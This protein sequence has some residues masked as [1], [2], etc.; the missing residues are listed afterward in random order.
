MITIESQ[1]LI[2]SLKQDD[3]DAIKCFLRCICKND[4]CEHAWKYT[5]HVD[6]IQET[7]MQTVLSLTIELTPDNINLNDKYISYRDSGKTFVFQ[8]ASSYQTYYDMFKRL[9]KRNL[10]N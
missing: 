4:E 8:I 6:E 7:A 2:G 9:I 5:I 3:R 10:W 1:P